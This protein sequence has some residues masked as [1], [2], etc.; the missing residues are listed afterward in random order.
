MR[1]FEV[2][3]TARYTYTAKLDIRMNKLI[4]IYTYTY[5]VYITHIM[6]VL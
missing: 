3:I 2:S 1:L 6:L 5:N 4:Y